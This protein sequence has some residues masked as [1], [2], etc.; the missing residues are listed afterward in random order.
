MPTY[1]YRCA[2]CDQHLEIVQ[3]MTDDPITVCA[4]CGGEMRKV[5]HPVGIVLKGSGFYRTDNRSGSKSSG[6]GGSGDS[7]SSGTKD[8]GSKDSKSGSSDSK[9]KDS[10]SKDSKSGSRDSKSQAKSA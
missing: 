4:A 1:H 9:S 7:G 6:S 2:Q 10:G 8:S 3:S 5:L